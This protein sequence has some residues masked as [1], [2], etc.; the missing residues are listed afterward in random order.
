MTKRFT[1][2]SVVITRVINY[3][4]ST[5]YFVCDGVVSPPQRSLNLLR[6]VLFKME[7]IRT[8]FL[9]FFKESM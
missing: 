1:D 2:S 6:L 5:L 8:E 7:G 4:W 9:P 3:L